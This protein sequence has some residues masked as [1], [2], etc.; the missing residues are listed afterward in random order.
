MGE[1]RQRMTQA[2]YEAWLEFYRM[3]PFDDFHR[4]HRPA[5]LVSMSLGG[6]DMQPRLDWL[7]PDP[8]TLGL[9]DADL[10]TMRALGFTRKEA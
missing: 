3:Y 10:S 6:G 8:G 7:Q 9:S 1:L 4:F 2:E 5:A